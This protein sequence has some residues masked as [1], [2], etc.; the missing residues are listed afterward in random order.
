MRMNTRDVSAR[1]PGYPTRARFTWLATGLVLLLAVVITL[2]GCGVHTESPIFTAAPGDY[3]CHNADG[4]A[5]P[6][7]VWCY[8]V[9]GTH[10]CCSE[11]DICAPNDRCRYAGH[12]E[13]LGGALV[14]MPRQREDGK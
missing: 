1:E 12:P 4:S 2:I 7:A 5:R 11:Y 9:D 8:P 6:N 3:P 10:T 14:E 13:T